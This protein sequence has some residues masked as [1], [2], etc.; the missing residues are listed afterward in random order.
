MEAVVE[1]TDTPKET[2]E[3]GQTGEVATPPAQ[4]KANI[5]ARKAGKSAAATGKRKK[6]R[7]PET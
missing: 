4:R 2:S 6:N 5:S 7:R 1:Q 3:L